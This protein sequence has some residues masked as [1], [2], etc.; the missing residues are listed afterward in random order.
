MSVFDVGTAMHAKYTTIKW[1]LYNT[2]NADKMQVYVHISNNETCAKLCVSR[3]W[4]VDGKYF[5]N[6]YL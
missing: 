2:N 5:D 1:L 6:R 4:K 3:Y